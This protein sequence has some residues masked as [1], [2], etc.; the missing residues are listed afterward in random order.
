M[1]SRSPTRRSPNA[2]RR[3]REVAG[4]VV[5]SSAR[6]SSGRRRAGRLPALVDY[7]YSS[8]SRDERT[9]WQGRSRADRPPP[10]R[11]VIVGPAIR[12][13]SLC[14]NQPS[15]TRPRRGPPAV[16]AGVEGGR[17]EVSCRPPRRHFASKNGCPLTSRR[18]TRAPVGGL[19][20]PLPHTHQKTHFTS[21]YH[22]GTAQDRVPLR[23]PLDP[24]LAA[25]AGHLAD[26]KALHLSL[27]AGQF[28][29]CKQEV[30][31]SI[32]VGSTGK[33]S[34]SLGSSCSRATWLGCLR[35]VL[36]RA[37]G[38]RGLP[39]D[40]PRSRPRRKSRRLLA[41]APAS[42][43]RSL[44]GR[45]RFARVTCCPP[46]RPP[47]RAPSLALSFPLCWVCGY[48]AATRY[49]PRGGAGEAREGVLQR[50][51]RGGWHRPLHPQCLLRDEDDT[52]ARGRVA[53]STTAHAPTYRPSFPLLPWRAP[54]E[55]LRRS[56]SLW[57]MSAG[58][59]TPPASSCYSPGNLRVDRRAASAGPRASSAG[60][61]P[62]TPS[63]PPPWSGRS[64]SSRWS[65]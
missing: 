42:C 43:R 16:R 23:V 33:A 31:G 51:P 62:V 26:L 41:I 39:L 7:R 52:S 18:T 8:A 44:C 10:R 57:A 19:T 50:L 5:R 40:G 65:S 53:A 34:P 20:G 37:S 21:G 38:T 4:G 29:F 63:D 3:S 64:A 45:T 47:C 54:S 17:S 30:T 49:F 22:S 46:K 13:T 11:S 48:A 58:P 35:G 15:G 60:S 12:P 9:A 61:P 28:S 56:R 2:R 36:P 32:P 59:D 25:L 6:G 14:S 55:E 24:D 27:P 1:R